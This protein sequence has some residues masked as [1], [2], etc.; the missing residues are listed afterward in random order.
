MMNAGVLNRIL[1]TALVLSVVLGPGRNLFAQVTEPPIVTIVATDH[2]AAEAEQDI[3]VFT[4]NRTGTVE[5]SLLVFYELSGTA[6]NGV[7]Y[8]E[9]PRSITIPA[10]AASAPI[11]I[12][13]IND[14]LAEGTE[15]VVARLVPSP[16]ASPIEPY[17][18]GFPSSDVILLADNDTPP[19]NPPPS[20]RILGPT[21]NASFLAPATLALVARAEPI[22]EIHSVEFFA[23]DRRI[24]SATFEPT[25]CSVCPVWVLEWT[26]VLAGEYNV[27]AKATDNLG[28]I[29]WSSAIHITVR[30]PEV[31]P[32]ILVGR[33]SVWKYLDDGSDQGT[34]WREPGFV[35]SEW[36]AGPAQ[37]GFGDG[38]EATVLRPG[39]ETRR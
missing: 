11:M 12:K 35:D 38:D 20:V 39:N 25:K 22:S 34:T 24:G 30:S 23:G 19:T 3:G 7:D 8:V 16:T 6:R 29:A 36:Q 1:P 15:T 4:V 28:A 21:N 27:T 33:G 37:L 10:G 14:A 18:V 2:H 32:I 13:P 26:N 5:A 31:P 17:R 9:L